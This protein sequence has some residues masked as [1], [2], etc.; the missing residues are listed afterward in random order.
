V[1]INENFGTATPGISA[2]T[3]DASDV[4]IDCSAGGYGR[5]A[6]DPAPTGADTWNCRALITPDGRLVGASCTT[7]PGATVPNSFFYAIT[8]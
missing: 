4:T 5:I 3:Y 7:G 2:C 8:G 1:F 6:L